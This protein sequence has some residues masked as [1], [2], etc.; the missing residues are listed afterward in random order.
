[1]MTRANVVAATIAAVLLGVF[2]VASVAGAACQLPVG[3]IGDDRLAETTRCLNERVQLL[4]QRLET[5]RMRNSISETIARDVKA[6]LDALEQ[7]RARAASPPGGNG[8]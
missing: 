5:E 1:M 4:E 2:T 3:Y 8:R 6:R 7:D